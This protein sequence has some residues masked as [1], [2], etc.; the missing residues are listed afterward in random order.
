MLTK[1]QIQQLKA[2][3]NKKERELSGTFLAEGEKLVGEIV[4]SGWPVTALYATA[5]WPLLSDSALPLQGYRVIVVSD[6]ELKRISLLKNPRY[7]VAVVNKPLAPPPSLSLFAD[8]SLF[9]DT[10][11]DPGNMGTILRI[12]DW[13]G[14]RQVVATPDSVDAF[15]PKVVQSTMGAIM[16]VT[17]HTLTP[18]DFFGQKALL[19]P[20]VPVYGAA[21]N[22]DNLYGTSFAAPG[23]LVMGNES[24]G[25]S[26]ETA[27][28]INRLLLIPPFGSGSETSESLNVAV[29]TAIICAEIR[30]QQNCI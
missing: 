26:F 5:D 1:K 9:L 24:K 10:V 25:I 13:F 22:G 8:W 19:A 17:V 29:A 23:V 16:R 11:Q 27:R 21:L 20:E 30:R 3:E 4:A 12:A 14:I 18:A 6:D 28:Y 2:L 15:H 7:V